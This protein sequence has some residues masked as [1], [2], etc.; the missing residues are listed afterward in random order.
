MVML[1]LKKKYIFFIFK[2]K[3]FNMD[4]EDSKMNRGVYTPAWFTIIFFKKST[5]PWWNLNS[6]QCLLELFNLQAIGNTLSVCTNW[7]DEARTGMTQLEL[8]CKC[9]SA[10]NKSGWRPPFP[11]LQPG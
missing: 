9:I 11:Q 6:L 2:V 1:V 8:S 4:L 3:L 5:S 10:M 7:T